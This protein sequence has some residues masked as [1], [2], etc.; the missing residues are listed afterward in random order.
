MYQLCI[1]NYLHCINDLWDDKSVE[2]QRLPLVVVFLDEIEHRE[3]EEL[4]DYA[5]MLSEDKE[6]EHPDD[7]VL[8]VGV[9]YSV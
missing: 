5:Q 2:V 6:V 7:R 4:E 9:V 1:F 3:R 8:S